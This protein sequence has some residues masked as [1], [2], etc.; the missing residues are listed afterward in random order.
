MR[1][2]FSLNMTVYSEE[3][4]SAQQCVVAPTSNVRESVVVCSLH[5]ALKPWHLKRILQLVLLPFP[6]K[7]AECLYVV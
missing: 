5:T 7:E 3:Q 2:D 1:S 4:H 6:L